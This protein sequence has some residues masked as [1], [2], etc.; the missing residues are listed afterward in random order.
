MTARNKQRVPEWNCC[1]ECGC[2]D[3]RACEGGCFWIRK[4]TRDVPGLC[5]ACADRLD[6]RK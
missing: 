2:T 5:S 6:L 1:G 4:P 3:E